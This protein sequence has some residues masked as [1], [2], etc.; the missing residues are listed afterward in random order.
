MA[1]AMMRK[2]PFII[3]VLSI[4]LAAT[5]TASAAQQRPNKSAPAPVAQGDL[6]ADLN[7]A[8]ELYAAGDYA[9]ALA[10][11]RKLEARV[12]AQFG[13]DHPAYGGAL[14][15]MANILKEQGEYAEA[16]SL[17]RRAL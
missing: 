2:G 17:F 9:A 13:T 12:K 16:E 15:T 6:N 3:A 4:F 7:R 8:N 11:A 5:S 10:E 1:Q 14:H